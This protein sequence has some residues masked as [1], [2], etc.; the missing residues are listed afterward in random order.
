LMT[1]DAAGL[2]DMVR[3]VGMD[4][5]A[6]SGRLVAKAIMQADRKGTKALDEY[7]TLMRRV[8]KQTSGNQQREIGGYST[9]EQLQAHLDKGMIKM[10][11]GL[12]FHSALNML[13]PAEQQKL[14][15]P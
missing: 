2:V 6:L 11:L 15:P 10:G 5:A 4:A 1:G 8:V 7:T 13:R 12:V 3:G 9:N 14:L